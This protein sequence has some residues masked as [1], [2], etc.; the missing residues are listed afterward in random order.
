MSTVVG[1]IASVLRSKELVKHEQAVVID[2][3]NKTIKK[4]VFDDILVLDFFPLDAIGYSKLRLET[5]PIVHKHLSDVG[6]CDE[7]PVDYI[8][9]FLATEPYAY[10]EIHLQ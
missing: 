1:Q 9:F 6:V 4:G 8:L 7:V 2:L 5:S 3:L 10:H